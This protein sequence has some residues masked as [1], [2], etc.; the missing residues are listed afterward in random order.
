MKIVA[1]EQVRRS[2]KRADNVLKV[3]KVSCTTT[4]NHNYYA[5]FPQFIIQKSRPN[6]D[7]PGSVISIDEDLPAIDLPS[8]K[9]MKSNNNRQ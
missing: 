8:F 5:P 6:L 1:D 7:S 4:K 2:M 3:I 9:V